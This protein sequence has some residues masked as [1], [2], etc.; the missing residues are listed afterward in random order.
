MSGKSDPSGAL[1]LGTAAGAL[2]FFKGFRT[3][4]EYKIVSDTPRIPIRSVPMGLAHFRGQ[5]QSAKA[6]WGWYSAAQRWYWFASR[7]CW[8]T[9]A[10][11]NTVLF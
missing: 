2:I 7:C 6:R 10:H 4:R 9:W 1:L 5:A 3:L 8:H 11:S